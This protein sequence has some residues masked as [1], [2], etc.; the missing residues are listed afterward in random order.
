[1]T[2]LREM[3]GAPPAGWDAVTVDPPGG[4]VLQG[5]AWAAHRHRQG[6]RPRFVLFDDRRAALVLT[7]A[8]PPLPGFLAYC[9]RGPI[10]A[11]DPPALVAARAE[12][13]AQ[14][15]RAEGAT[16]FA[17]DPELDADPAYDA[18]MAAAG[19][20]ATEEIQP[21]RHRLVLDLPPGTDEAGLLA[22][23]SKSARQR[24][25][26][27]ESGGTIV[28][29]DAAGERLAAFGAQMD[30]TAR[31]KR[32]NFGSD[33]GFVEWWQRVLGAGCAR[34]LVA[35]HEGRLLGGLLVYLQGGHWATAFSADDA[36]LRR[37]HP[38]SMHLLRWAAI[39]GALAA[40][41]PFIDLGGVDVPGARRRP[42]P[43]E[44]A[45]GMLEHKLG[46]GARWVESAGAREIVLRPGIYRADLALRRLRRRA[47]GLP[48]R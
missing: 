36:T 31:R 45:W 15:L 25:H 22:A 37:D 44:P 42:E 41:V 38:G 48:V 7:R 3:L 14:R 8:R 18:A 33:R 27:A 1:M 23:M 2:A 34:F 17:V 35:E 28:R 4:H 24:I 40:G 46:F 21:S 6:W 9:P 30:A 11:G 13:L 5:T 10:A 26:A 16:I 39:R 43:G 47:L 19:F 12:A 32:F 29:E 20:R